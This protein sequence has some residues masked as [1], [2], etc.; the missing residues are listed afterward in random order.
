M[1]AVAGCPGG[2]RLSVREGFGVERNN[3]RDSLY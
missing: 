3:E 2:C 1:A